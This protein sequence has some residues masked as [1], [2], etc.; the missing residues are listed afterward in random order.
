VVG[1]ATLPPVVV[2]VTDEEERPVVLRVAV[3]R[4][5][6]DVVR[7]EEEVEDGVVVGVLA[8]PG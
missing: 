1:V 8:T 6:E 4:V 2:G 3:V 5:E 7:D